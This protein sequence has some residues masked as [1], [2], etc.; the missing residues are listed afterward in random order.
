MMR[1]LLVGGTSALGKVLRPIL[2]QFSEV[3][4]AGRKGCDVEIDLT[5]PSEKICLPTNIDVVI[6]VVAHFGGD[7]FDAI[8]T[9]E[10]VNAVGALKL[11]NASVKI[12]AKHFIHISSINVLLD[13]TSEYF[14]AY[15]LSKRHADDLIQL[16]CE[17]ANLA[18]AI[19]RPS[20]IYGDQDEFKKH[21]FFLYDCVDKA[22][23]DDDIIIYGSRNP[24]RNYLHIE[25]LCKL[26]SAVV[27]KRIKG[28]YSCANPK[29][30]TILEVA[31]AAIRAAGSSSSVIF[32][33]EKRDI[34]DNIFVHD[35]ALYRLAGIYPEIDIE[36]G[37]TRL[38]ISKMEGV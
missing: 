28:I 21:Q 16:Y 13:S 4:T 24:M 36:E 37:I 8:C 7:S 34:S 23:R 30:S 1:I 38:V 3:I 5:W 32:N 2:A 22:L 6:N 15:S 27:T 10:I 17:K 12:N 31:D 14:G 18:Y 25:D 11:C 33:G 9:S 26:I 29:D 35:D 20:Q 19:L